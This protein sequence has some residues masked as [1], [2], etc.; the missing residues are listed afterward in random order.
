[1]DTIELRINLKNGITMSEVGMLKSKFANIRSRYG[2]TYCDVLQV[3]S[4]RIL[5]CN[6]Y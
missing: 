6:G 1:M 4:S 5:N 3:T 2:Y